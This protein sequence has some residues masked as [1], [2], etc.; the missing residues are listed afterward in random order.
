MKKNILN[1][2][3]IAL[4]LMIYGLPVVSAEVYHSSTVEDGNYVADGSYIIGNHMF[5]YDY[6]FTE[7]F[8]GNVNTAVVMFGS[9]SIDITNVK[10]QDDMVIYYKIMDDFWIN[11][12][13]GSDIEKVPDSFDILYVNGKCV[14][15]VC[16]EEAIE[17]TFKPSVNDS[18]EEK[19]SLLSYGDKI[20]ADALPY[21]KSR[22][23]YVFKGWSI[24]ETSEIFDLTTS[25]T[26]D[27]VLVPNW[28][29]IK[30]NVTY[31]SEFDVDSKIERECYYD[32]EGN[33]CEFIEYTIAT[34]PNYHFVGWSTMSEESGADRVVYKVGTDMA[35]VLGTNPDVVL[36]AVWEPNEYEITY[37]LNG[38]SFTSD[39]IIRKYNAETEDIQLPLPVRNGYSF[40]WWSID[41]KEYDGN[42]LYSDIRLKAIWEENSVTVTYENETYTCLYNDCKAP[43][44]SPVN[45]DKSLVFDGWMSDNGYVYENGA[46]IT[47]DDKING[48]VNLTAKWANNDRY[49]IDYDLDGG[50]FENGTPIVMYNKDETNITIPEPKKI[51][52]TFM[53]WSGATFEDGKLITT[54]SN[55]SI[56]ANWENNTYTIN[57]YDKNKNLVDISECVYDSDDDCEFKKFTSTQLFDDEKIELLGWSKEEPREGTLED[58]YYG[59]NVSVRNLTSE[60]NGY[61]NLYPIYKD[62]NVYYNVKYIIPDFV[63]LKE[64][65]DLVEGSFKEGTELTLPELEL[66]ENADEYTFVGWKINDVQLEENKNTF[67]VDSATTV[68]AVWEKVA[69]E[70]VFN[71]Y[72]MDFSYQ[73]VKFGDVSLK[74]YL[75]PITENEGVY[76]FDNEF[77]NV[78]SD[79]SKLQVTILDV[80]MS[81]ENMDA[82]ILGEY[83]LSLYQGDLLIGTI[84][85]NTSENLI[86]K[87]EENL[88]LTENCMVFVEDGY[89][90]VLT[91]VETSEEVIIE[92]SS[93]L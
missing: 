85:L 16:G 13:T 10:T 12:I 41:D 67:I 55:M 2:L 69:P 83:S 57:F 84:T 33:S 91:N 29:A 22:A 48:M 93:E 49:S 90:V 52:Y 78:E 44:E 11:S 50:T 56:K 38:G 3:I 23:G 39:N 59:V 25:V 72:K 74:T 70:Q 58:I 92:P 17:V 35:T 31:E 43:N 9:S 76:A 66:K 18:F 75:K 80:D 65:T 20:S 40:K 88:E 34:K 21:V 32:V 4:I 81:N 42:N 77:V 73:G 51:G 61:I 24:E 82:S 54:N 8:D 79:D 26:N 86:Y 45:T 71:T 89:K 87:N 28:E 5:S 36:Y 68:E 60:A 7:L 37:D 46:A 63:Q 64:G 53:G 15:P 1:N 30:Y 27:M 19:K 14:D 47:E 6:D 62:N